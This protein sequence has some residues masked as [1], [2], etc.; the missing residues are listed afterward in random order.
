MMCANKTNGLFELTACIF[1]TAERRMLFGRLRHFRIRIRKTAEAVA[2]YLTLLGCDSV[3]ITGTTTSGCVR[4]T[5]LDA[6]SLN[7]HVALVEELLDRS[8]AS[9]AVN[10]CDMNAKYADVVKTSEVVAFLDSLSSGM[11]ELPKG[12]GA[13][14][15]EKHAVNY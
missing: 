15:R 1:G 7:Y 12:S 4:A 10:L 11:Y 6:F 13:V 8:Q 9:H 14:A 2:S 3:I 5:V